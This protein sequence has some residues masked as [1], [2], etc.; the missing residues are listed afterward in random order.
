MKKI[1]L[2]LLLAAVMGAGAGAAEIDDTIDG[3]WGVK[4]GTSVAEANR[5]HLPLGARR[6]HPATRRGRDDPRPVRRRSDRP[7]VYQPREALD[8]LAVPADRHGRPSHAEATLDRRSHDREHHR[9]RRD[10]LGHVRRVRD[11]PARGEGPRAQGDRRG[12]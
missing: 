8:R 10:R 11:N 12:G 2:A 1:L 9:P 3:V 5:D 4:F 7:D 6:A